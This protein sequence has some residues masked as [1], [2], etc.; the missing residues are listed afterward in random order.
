MGHRNTNALSNIKL[1]PAAEIIRWYPLMF[2]KRKKSI[3]IEKSWFKTFLSTFYRVLA[4][5]MVGLWKIHVPV[6]RWTPPERKV[7]FFFCRGLPILGV[8]PCKSTKSYCIRTTNTI[9]FHG[10]VR[11][12][13]KNRESGT[14]NAVTLHSGGVQRATSA[15]IFRKP[16]IYDA[17]MQ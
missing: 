16:T 13:R 3:T 12:S 14:K 5:Y 2:Q 4:S 9:G 17:R 15:W 6:A 7:T 8:I 11:D 10:F 1:Y